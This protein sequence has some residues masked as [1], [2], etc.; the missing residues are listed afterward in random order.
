MASLLQKPAKGTT[1]A[2]ASAAEPECAVRDRHD[3][4]QAAE[5]AHVDHAAHGVHHAAGAEE[6]QGLE[7][8]VREQVEHAGH[9]AGQRAGAQ[10][11]EHVAQLAD[12]GIGQHAL[13]IVL[14]HADDAGQERP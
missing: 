12:R 14:R 9:D 5:A 6:Q 4:P 13:Q 7:E 8:G 10:R 2:R 3:P 11:Q 1:P